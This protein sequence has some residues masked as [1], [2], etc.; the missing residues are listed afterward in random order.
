VMNPALDNQ[1]GAWI[2]GPAGFDTFLNPGGGPPTIA[3]P[4]VGRAAAGPVTVAK[5]PK[6]FQRTPDQLRDSAGKLASG[7]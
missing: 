6:L 7:H 5:T 1:I 3:G 4:R 2:S